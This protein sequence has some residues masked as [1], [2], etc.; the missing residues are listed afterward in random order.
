[1]EETLMLTRPKVKSLSNIDGIPIKYSWYEKSE[2]QSA[3]LSLIIKKLI[4][5]G[6]APTRITILSPGSTP[7]F[8]QTHAATPKI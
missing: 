6:I 3:L 4:S 7:V 5:E 8:M 2:E 1:V